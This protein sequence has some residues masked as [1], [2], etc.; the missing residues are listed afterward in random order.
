M[1]ES[2]STVRLAAMTILREACEGSLERLQSIG[3]DTMG[4]LSS[5]LQDEP[6]I[7]QEAASGICSIIKNNIDSNG[8]PVIPQDTVCQMMSAVVQ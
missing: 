6:K 5:G 8:D 3:I 4:I 7:A 2:N 1:K